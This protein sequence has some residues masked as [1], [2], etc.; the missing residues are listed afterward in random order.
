MGNCCKFDFNWKTLKCLLFLLF[1]VKNNKFSSFLKRYN[2]SRLAWSSSSYGNV[3]SISLP[4][5]YLWTPDLT[6]YNSADGRMAKLFRDPEWPAAISSA[7]QVTNVLPLNLRS[8]C[9]PQFDDSGELH[10]FQNCS[11]KFGSWVHNKLNIDF[12]KDSTQ[13]MDLYQMVHRDCYK[14]TDLKSAISSITYECCPEQYVDIT[15]K[16]RIQLN[17]LSKRCENLYQTI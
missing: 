3:T 6:L 14:V 16:M 4:V 15:Y 9:R 2:D 8:I 1:K 10:E 12:V 17:K 5:K 13:E 11:L 7:G